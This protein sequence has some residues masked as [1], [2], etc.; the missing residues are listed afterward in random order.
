MSLEG[1]RTRV[2]VGDDT[3][4]TAPSRAE[5]MAMG[6]FAALLVG[7][8]VVWQLS[9]A[10][11]RVETAQL[12]AG[13][14][15]PPPMVEAPP[16]MSAAPGP[17]PALPPAFVDAPALSPSS[18]AGAPALVVDLSDDAPS[19]TTS[20]QV[21]DQSGA[22]AAGS[23]D[24]MF[25]ARLGVGGDAGARAR[26]M[27]NPTYTLV[28]GTMLPAVLETA[29]QS[30][31]P[32][33]VRAV[34]SRNVAG[35]DGAEILVPR[36]SRLV[37]RYRAGVGLGQSR[38]FV[39]W[40]RLVRPDGVTVDLAAPGADALG[41]AGLSGRVDRHILQRFGGAALLTLLNVGVTAAG[42]GGSQVIIAG[43]GA[44]NGAATAF[45]RELD[46]APTVKV[47]PGATVNA[48]LT[49]DLDFS[50]LAEAP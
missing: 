50:V 35:F 21:G 41:R 13:V 9:T 29:V 15:A 37:G 36:G 8:V 26:A 28:Q 22:E 32:G 27:G 23:R 17:L 43:G 7:G 12:T 16:Q 14:A 31:L 19:S 48:F 10:G 38:A 25:A 30:D 45:Q 47:S 3:L 5:P 11:E 44:V 24:E 1:R 18:A 6:V 46:I 4:R 49:R 33:Y 20:L 40:T 39:I 34:I 2:H 42:S